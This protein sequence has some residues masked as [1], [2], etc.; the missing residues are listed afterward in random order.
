MA[1]IVSL[2]AYLKIDPIILYVLIV[3][4]TAPWKYHNFIDQ[5]LSRPERPLCADSRS[6]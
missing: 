5:F 3:R 4:M 1:S 6:W 2:V